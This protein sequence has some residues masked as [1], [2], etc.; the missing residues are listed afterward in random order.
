[1]TPLGR[2][3]AN[4]LALSLIA[5]LFAT[6]ACDR[7]A[8]PSSEGG[9]TRPTEGGIPARVE[10]PSTIIDALGDMEEPKAPQVS[11]LVTHPIALQSGRI[12]SGLGFDSRSGLLVWGEEVADC[13]PYS[14]EEAR[15]ALGRVEANLLAGFEFETPL[16]KTLALAALF[17]AVERRAMDQAPAFLI[18]ANVQGT[19]KTTLARRIHVCLTGRDMPTVTYPKSPEEA[20]K[21]L[22]TLLL[23]GPAM[24]CFDNIKDRETFESSTL[25]QILTAPYFEQRMLGENKSARVPTD[26]FFTVTGN[27]LKLGRDELSRFLE[28]KLTSTEERPENRTFELPD[29]VGHGLS[30]RESVLRDVVGIVAGCRVAKGKAPKASRFTAWDNVV[31]QPLLWAGGADPAEGFDRNHAH[32]EEALMEHAL[33]AKLYQGFDNELFQPGDVMELIDPFHGDDKELSQVLQQL[34][35]QRKFNTFKGVTVAY[36]GRLMSGLVGKWMEIDGVK[37]RLSKSRTNIG[38]KYWIRTEFDDM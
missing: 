18:S 16:D 4:W 33:L 21:L 30:I 11:G 19:G 35:E 37:M 9:F 3:R 36:A 7:G 2:P 22:F 1:M 8:A 31:R 27:H 29:I 20:D 10:V 28:V 15:E 6:A 13:R 17:T 5:A 25:N 32:S 26:V 24:V 14:Q 34:S 38:F 12:L 23:A